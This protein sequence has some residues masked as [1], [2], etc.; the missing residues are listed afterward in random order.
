ML[1]EVLKFG[2]KVIEK[3]AEI[4]LAIPRIALSLIDGE[5]LDDLIDTWHEITHDGWTD[6]HKD[7]EKF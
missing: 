2:W 5:L 6:D 7:P 1:V 4:V 3:G